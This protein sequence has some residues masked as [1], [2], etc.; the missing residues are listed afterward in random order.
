[1]QS[2]ARR[3][4]NSRTSRRTGFPRRRS[5]VP[6]TLHPEQPHTWRRS[7]ESPVSAYGSRCR[8]P[9]SSDGGDRERASGRA[10]FGRGSSSSTTCARARRIPGRVRRSFARGSRCA[11]NPI[12]PR[13]GRRSGQRVRPRDTSASGV[14]RGTAQ[15]P[16]GHRGSRGRR[17][18]PFRFVGNPEPGERTSRS[19]PDRS[20]SL[21]S[22]E[23][24]SPGL[25]ARRAQVQVDVRSSGLECASA[26]HHDRFRVS[27]AGKIPAPDPA[28]DHHASRGCANSILSGL[29]RFRFTP[30]PKAPGESNRK[31]GAAQ[32]FV[33]AGPRSASPMG[34][35][36]NL[37]A[38]YDTS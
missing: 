9:S 38:A 6:G 14:G 34:E 25:P 1:M 17:A 37:G 3:A 12:P 18:R 28:S 27:G 7:Q 35:A 5:T 36:A 23:R 32:V 20:R 4:A 8:G 22:A 31:C 2:L 29:V 15:S 10:G 11:S 19:L 33:R 30:Q 13:H 26:D 21:R 24:S 16:L